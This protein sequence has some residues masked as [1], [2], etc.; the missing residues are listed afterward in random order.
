MIFVLIADV[1]DYVMN[2]PSP[3]KYWVTFGKPSLD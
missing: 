3:D 1:A 2:I